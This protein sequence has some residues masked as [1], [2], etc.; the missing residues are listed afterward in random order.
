[1]D[2]GVQKKFYTAR[3][4]RMFRA[5]FVDDNDYTLMENLLSDCLDEEV[6]IIKYLKTELSIKSNK[7]R[8]KR[9]DL[10][11]EVKGKRINLEL[12][13]SFG[14]IIK[15]RNFNYFTAFYSEQTAIGETYDYAT[16]F[17]HIDL[18][19]DMGKSESVKNEYTVYSKTSG[20]NYI[21]N[22]KII[23]FNMDRIMKFW[24]DKDRKGIEKYKHLL[25]LDLDKESLEEL[26]KNDKIVDVYRKKIM[27]KNEEYDFI[28]PVSAER[29]AIMLHN[30]ELKYER[31]QGV[32]EGKRE[33][34]NK[35]LEKNIPIETIVEVTGISKKEIDDIKKRQS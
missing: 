23:V 27:R 20:D 17:I 22:F 2:I 5:V 31:E 9:L 14:K 32:E 29:D 33:V 3:N 13:T 15:V 8:V 7:E 34:I 26:S 10:L 24:Y 21:D 30:T 4:D 35:M 16:E 11:V 25:M 6:K 12:N 18:S 1:M 19:Y 28:A